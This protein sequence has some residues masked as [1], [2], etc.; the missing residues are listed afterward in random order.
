MHFMTRA[1]GRGLGTSRKKD[2]KKGDQAYELQISVLKYSKFLTS[3]FLLSSRDSY[4]KISLHLW[5][6]TVLIQFN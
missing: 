1:N 6:F 2:G 4:D 5:P 3:V